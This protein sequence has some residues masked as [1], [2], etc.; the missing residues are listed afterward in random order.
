MFF[1]DGEE[2]FVEWNEKDSIY[3]ARHLADVLA[4]KPHHK[5]EYSSENS[6]L[7]AIV[8]KLA[9]FAVCIAAEWIMHNIVGVK[10]T[11]NR[12][13]CHIC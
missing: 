1:L 4:K 8:S 11:L 3:G 13:I 9:Q 2:A 10:S 7:D 5:K 12:L 6:M